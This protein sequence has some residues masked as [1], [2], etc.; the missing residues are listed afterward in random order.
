MGGEAISR[1]REEILPYFFGEERSLYACHHFPFTDSAHEAVL[2]CSATGHEYE[3]CHRATR[4]LAVQLARAGYATMRF[5]YS[6][7]GDSAGEYAQASLA[8]WQRDVAA[9]AD[10][11]RR[12]TGREQL[13]MVGVRLGAA[14]AAQ[15]AAG[16]NDASHLVLYAP[17]MDGAAL[18]AEWRRE[19]SDFDRKYSR[20]TEEAPNEVLGFPLTEAFCAELGRELAPRAPG[21][22]LRRVLILAEFPGESAI[23][24]AATVLA[25]RGA[26]VT[27]EQVN[28]PAVWR[29]D[30]SE[31]IVPF[32]VLRHIADWMKEG[33]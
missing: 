21:P 23:Q 31:G 32:K 17:V 19:Q 28:G 24:Q 2:I 6:G 27:V 14:L 26:N 1:G 16:R 22:A 10:E 4:Q 15:V 12:R 7:T 3:R 18:L 33:L 29:R 11:C 8:Q 13:C 30:P 9:A 25:S 20:A 5:D